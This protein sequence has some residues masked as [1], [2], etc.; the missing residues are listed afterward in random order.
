MPLQ[1]PRPAADRIT[2]LSSNRVYLMTPIFT[3]SSLGLQHPGYLKVIKIYRV[4]AGKDGS[5]GAEGKWSIASEDATTWP[6]AFIQDIILR[7]NRAHCH[8]SIVA[9]SSMFRGETV[10]QADNGKDTYDQGLRSQYLLSVQAFDRQTAQTRFR[11]LSS[12]S[13]VHCRRTALFS[14]RRQLR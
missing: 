7:R 2:G 13:I 12:L 1:I 9:G 6:R 8:L 11:A 10:S 4:R 5:Q 14:E 3:S